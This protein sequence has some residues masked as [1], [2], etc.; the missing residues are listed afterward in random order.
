MWVWY[1][2]SFDI[3]GMSLSLQHHASVRFCVCKS[4]WLSTYMPEPV[5]MWRVYAG[6]CLGVCGAC[7]TDL[8]QNEQNMS[9]LSMIPHN[10]FNILASGDPN[11]ILTS[12]YELYSSPKTSHCMITFI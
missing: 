6:T 7:L 12:E 2:Y 9:Y 1:K 8:A 3:R 4:V 11:L 10:L 5:Y